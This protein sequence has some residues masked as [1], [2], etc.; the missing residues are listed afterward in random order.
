MCHEERKYT[1][2]EITIKIEESGR[3]RTEKYLEKSKILKEL[4]TIGNEGKELAT[5]L[6]VTEA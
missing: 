6:K 2:G 5:I 4:S 3:I 1:E